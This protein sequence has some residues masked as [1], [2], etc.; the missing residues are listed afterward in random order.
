MIMHATKVIVKQPYVIMYQLIILRVLYVHINV[1]YK[2]S[3]Q[4]IVFYSLQCMLK[5]LE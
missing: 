3:C 5:D 2:K 4:I 1:L